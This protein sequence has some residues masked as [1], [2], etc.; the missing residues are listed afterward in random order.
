M[1]EVAPEVTDTMLDV[2]FTSIDR[3]KEF[4]LMVKNSPEEKYKH[5]RELFVPFG[6]NGYAVLYEY[7]EHLDL[8]VIASIKHTKEQGFSGVV[9]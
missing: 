9:G 8:I 3:L 7:K 5:L 4:P 1:D 2:L 6:V